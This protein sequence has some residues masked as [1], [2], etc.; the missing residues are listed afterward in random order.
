MRRRRE[1]IEQE[2][3]PW[4]SFETAENWR[5]AEFLMT[6]GL[7]GSKRDEFLKL[8]AVRQHSIK[9]LNGTHHY[10]QIQ[11]RLDLPFDDDTK[12]C[13][14]IDDLP[15]SPDWHSRTLTIQG[16]A[17]DD[18]GKIMKEEHTM[19]Y[20]NPIECVQALLGSTHLRDHLEYEPVKKWLE[21]QDAP[22]ERVFDEM[23]TGDLWHELQ[24]S[25][26]LSSGHYEDCRLT[27]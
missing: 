20:R 18:A 5:V 14:M 23:N 17:L 10:P 16:D 4:G 9:A 22:R 24:V 6:S 3:G 26:V 11:E 15:Q 21:S 8:S 2:L 1:E 25:T 7:S 13:E 19:Y 12:L 27:I